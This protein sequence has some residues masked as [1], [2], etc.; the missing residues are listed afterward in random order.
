[1]TA[2]IT[3]YTTPGCS[4]CTATKRILDRAGI[5]YATVDL[6]DNPELVEQFKEQGLVSAPIVSAGDEVWSGMRP[7]KL[8]TITAGGH[9]SAA[10]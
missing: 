3:V 5:D 9:A 1:M 7:D 6:S 2:T 8:R 10:A 4:G